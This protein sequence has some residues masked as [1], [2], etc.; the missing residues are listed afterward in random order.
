M[1]LKS[2]K[3]SLFLQTQPD[4]VLVKDPLFSL[5][6]DAPQELAQIEIGKGEPGIRGRAGGDKKANGISAANPHP[7]VKGER[8]PVGGRAIHQTH[9]RRR[10]H[11]KPFAGARCTHRAAK[12]TG[13]VRRKPAIPP[14]RRPPSRQAPPQT[15]A[16]ET[17]NC[18]KTGKCN[19]K[20]NFAAKLRSVC[21]EDHK[22]AVKVYK[23]DRCQKRK[24]GV[25]YTKALNTLYNWR[26]AQSVKVL[27][28]RNLRGLYC[29]SGVK[30]LY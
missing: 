5:L 30:V 23:R 4:F 22:R 24:S 21:A 16:C 20:A 6:S 11:R 14:T 1:Y 19:K 27:K 17:N 2:R 7:V 28:N 13:T 3:F 12:K 10:K 26:K 29:L 18:A 15:G 9:T 8:R 25:N